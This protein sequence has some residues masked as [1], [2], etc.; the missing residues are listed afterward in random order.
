MGNN[1]TKKENYKKEQAIEKNRYSSKFMTIWHIRYFER[2]NVQ[3][4]KTKK[5]DF[6]HKTK[7]TNAT[8]FLIICNKQSNQ[9]E[10]QLTAHRSGTY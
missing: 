2:N 6:L 8:Y 7:T 1:V 5:T 10:R 4:E 9:S 3:T